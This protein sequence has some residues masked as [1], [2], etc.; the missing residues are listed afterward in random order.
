[1]DAR[2]APVVLDVR[3]GREFRRGHVP[4]AVHIPFQLVAIRASGVGASR[5]TPIV[6]YCGHGPRAWIAGVVLRALGFRNVTFLTG[7]WAGWVRA[8]LPRESQS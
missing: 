5:L 6:V 8:R 4:G 1:M 3:T 2:T 7:H